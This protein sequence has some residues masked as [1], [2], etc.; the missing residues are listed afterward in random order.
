MNETENIELLPLNYLKIF[1]RRK[2]Y[3]IIPVF[4]GLVFGICAGMILPKKYQAATILLVE[5]GKSDN[6]LFDKLTVSTTVKER[7]STI[8]ESMLGWHSMV[9]LIRRLGMQKDIKT[10]QQLENKVMAIRRDIS[11]KLRDSNIINLSYAGKDP[12]QTYNVVKN[13]SEIFIERNL[14][15]QNQETSDAIRFIEEQLKVYRGKIKSAEIANLKD[16][17]KTL[18]VDATDKHPLVKQLSEQIAAKEAELKAENLEYT[19]EAKLS[20]E[21]TNPLIED[22]RKAL[23][24]VDGG[25][26][27]G[28]TGEQNAKSNDLY[29]VMLLGQLEGVVAKDESVNTSVYNMLLQRLETAK[30][31]QRLQSSKEGTK[32]T[33]LDPPRI[34]LKPSKPNKTL[35]ALAGLFFGLLFGAALVVAIEFLDKS[36]IDVEDA[37][38]F[39]GVPLLGAI[40]KIKT[41][42]TVRQKREQTAWFYGLVILAGAAVIIITKAA[43]NFLS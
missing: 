23:D 6:P 4:I 3:I 19:E 31:T 29:K 38:K 11:I 24:S 17:L 42:A 37:K 5:E 30:I 15:V 2:D 1:F 39:I 28:L 13:I 35:V 10:P 32:Y 25:G 8:K 12:Q 40:S 26:S 27:I 21:A 34:P 33:V 14:E 43:A 16:K 20:L 18:L 41:E 22:I 7:L 36:F 9:E